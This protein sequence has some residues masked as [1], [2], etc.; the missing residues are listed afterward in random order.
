VEFRGRSALS[1]SALRAQL[2][3]PHS[4]RADEFEQAASARQIEAAYQEHGYHF[5]HVKVTPA[6]GDQAH[7]LVFEI[8]EGPRVRVESVTFTGTHTEP[9]ARLAGLIET[10]PPGALRR[11]LFRADTLER[12]MRV[13]LAH[14][15]AQGYATRRWTGRD[16]LPEDRT[17]SASPCPSR[18]RD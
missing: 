6:E 7:T 18:V 15:R 14:L 12:D 16:R 1:E 4:G 8:E 10:R 11:G 2:T 5:A 17:R 13:L 3:F 9:D